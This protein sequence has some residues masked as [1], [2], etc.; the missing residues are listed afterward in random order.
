MFISSTADKCEEP[1]QPKPDVAPQGTTSLQYSE[2]VLQCQSDK[3]T[4]MPTSDLSKDPTHKSKQSEMAKTGTSI[5]GEEGNE[6]FA[7]ERGHVGGA[8]LLV[9]PVVS[10]HLTSS[11]PSRPLVDAMAENFLESQRPSDQNCALGRMDE[12][13]DGRAK[14]LQWMETLDK[15]HKETTK[16]TKSS[17]LINKISTNCTIASSGRASTAYPVNSSTKIQANQVKLSIEVEYF[18]FLLHQF[19][20]QFSGL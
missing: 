19:L 8:E 18:V 3:C 9:V 4:G 2:R 1:C 15:S 16:E 7:K 11:N 13:T 10:T 14:G 12:E 20:L 17:I 6:L 5:R